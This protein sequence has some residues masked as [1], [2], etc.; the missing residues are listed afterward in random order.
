MRYFLTETEL[1]EYTQRKQPAAQARALA[2]AG[3]PFRM[4]NNRPVV[5]R[6]DTHPPESAGSS[7]RL[8][9]A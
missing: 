5:V 6:S 2:R 8:Q 3:V 1:I 7:V 9:L 4:V